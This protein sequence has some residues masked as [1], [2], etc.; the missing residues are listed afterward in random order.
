MLKNAKSIPG[1]VHTFL[2]KVTGFLVEYQRYLRRASGHKIC[3]NLWPMT[4]FPEDLGVS[5]TEDLM[6]LLSTKLYRDFGLP[7]LKRLAEEFGGLHIHC[8]GRYQHHVQTLL[9][10]GLKIYALEFHYPEMLLEDLA[11]LADQTVL[12]P[13]IILHKQSEFKNT[14]QFYRCLLEDYAHKFRFWFA[15]TEDDEDSLSFANQYG[16]AG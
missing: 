13:Y 7:Y 12:V 10:S 9:Q 6:P 11:P 5:F 8:C 4:F 1:K 16:E 2:E 14:S 3:G 15:C